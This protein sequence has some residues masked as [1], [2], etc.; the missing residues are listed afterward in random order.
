MATSRATAGAP[1][2][3]RRAVVPGHRATAPRRQDMPLPQ[4]GDVDVRATFSVDLTY[5]VT[6]R[7]EGASPADVEP[8]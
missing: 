2:P 6:A 5:L 3:L 7:L 8:S 1:A 4:P